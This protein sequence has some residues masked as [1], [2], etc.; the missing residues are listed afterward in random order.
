MSAFVYTYIHTYIHTCIHTYIHIY[1]YTYVIITWYIDTLIFLPYCHGSNSI[2]YLPSS[3]VLPF[4]IDVILTLGMRSVLPVLADSVGK[5]LPGLHPFQAE[6][7]VQKE[8]L[9]STTVLSNN[10]HCFVI[11]VS[12]AYIYIY[13]YIYGFVNHSFLQAYNNGV[14]WQVVQNVL[15]SEEAFDS[16]AFPRSTKIV[17]L[18]WIKCLE[19]KFSSKIFFIQYHVMEWNWQNLTD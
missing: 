2:P 3:T 4:Y 15:F 12:E 1:I 11:H 7:W 5:A 14:I 13:I 9:C 18:T 16:N 8:T 6:D 17:H 10:V 19:Q